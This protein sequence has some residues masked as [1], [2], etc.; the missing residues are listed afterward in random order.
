MPPLP[1]LRASAHR[2]RIDNV[3]V[4]FQQSAAFARA[5]TRG[6]GSAGRRTDRAAG[7]GPLS[8]ASASRAQRLHH[9]VGSLSTQLQ[10]TSMK[11]MKTRR[12]GA[13]VRSAA[14]CACQTNSAPAIRTQ[15]LQAGSGGRRRPPHAERYSGQRAF[16]GGKHAVEGGADGGSRRWVGRTLRAQRPPASSV[17][18]SAHMH[19]V[20]A[21]G[22]VVGGVGR[23]KTLLAE[24]ASRAARPAGPHRLEHFLP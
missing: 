19:P 9:T 23:E 8:D 3:K 5:T 17:A 2:E 10:I 16:E 1:S 21:A 24:K 14:R 15:Q 6:G 4:A 7:S 12:E 18:G 11:N 13:N 22:A 20:S